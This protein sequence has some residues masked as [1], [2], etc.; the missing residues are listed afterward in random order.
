MV[1][2]VGLRVHAVELYIDISM[3]GMCYGV[4]PQWLACSYCD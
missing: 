4:G 3:N 1:L 2:T